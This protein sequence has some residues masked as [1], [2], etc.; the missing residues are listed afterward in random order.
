M[1]KHSS[2]IRR[3]KVSSMFLALML[4]A[5]MLLASC[6]QM[7]DR[8][9]CEVIGAKLLKSLADLN[10]MEAGLQMYYLNNGK[11]PEKLDDLVPEVLTRLSRDPWDAPYHY[12][13]E[14]TG[15]FSL[16]S[17]GIKLAYKNNSF[18]SKVKADSDVAAMLEE[19]KTQRLCR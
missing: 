13:L 4:L 16:Y 19:I 8:A 15:N 3:L 1:I 2:D 12:K 18:S 17:E 11:F 5:L 6:G 10:S 9:K 7:D 14:E